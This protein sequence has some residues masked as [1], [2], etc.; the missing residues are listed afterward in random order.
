[1]STVIANGIRIAYEVHG[2]GAPLVLIAG[3][4]YDRWMWHKMVPGL[5]EQFQVIVFDNRGVGET[6]IAPGPYSAGLLAADTAALMQALGI[7]KA[8]IMGHSMGGF[9][10]QALAI[11]Y[12]ERV[13]KLILSATNF[14]GPNHVR[15]TQEAL[16]VLMDTT[17]DPI[18]RLKRGMAVST[19]PGFVE[20]HPEVVEAWLAYRVAH[21]IDPAGY[22][23]QLAVGLGLM[24][25]E[26]CFEEKLTVVSQPTLILHGEADKVVP[27]ENAALL[28]KQL[29]NSRVAIMPGVGHF[30]PF[31]APE[32]AVA[33]VTD[34]MNA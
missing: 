29:P 31:E 13:D 34:F 14:G 6:E 30:Y 2:E 3:L 21:P 11:E 20:A 16:V 19:A 7:E 17:G 12:P 15:I 25:K 9:V 26:A 23:A 8:A 1:M 22:Q 24:A 27:P 4:G 33:I 18:E 5:A 32:T 10:A 28:A